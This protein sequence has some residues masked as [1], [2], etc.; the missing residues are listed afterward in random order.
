MREKIAVSTKPGQSFITPKL[1]RCKFTFIID[2]LIVVYLSIFMK[3]RKFTIP[4]LDINNIPKAEDIAKALLPFID[5]DFIL[6]GKTRTDGSNIRK[7]IGNAIDSKFNLAQAKA[8]DYIITE[9]KGLPKLLT[10]C[11]DS[12]LVTS[13]GDYN[14]QVWNRIPNSEN[15]LIQ[16][17]NGSKI[18]A[19]DIIFFL[20]KL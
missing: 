9:K 3:I 11:I 14:L 17:T 19:K 2:F 20:S 1:D 6:T 13:E 16:Y 4:P 7:K 8:E 18:L 15:I 10:Y 5:S 12:Y